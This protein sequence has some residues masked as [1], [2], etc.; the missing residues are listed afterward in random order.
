MITKGGN[1]ML[2]GCALKFDKNL[3]D[4]ILGNTKKV[5]FGLLEGQ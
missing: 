2:T 3:K 4:V 5:N 1:Q